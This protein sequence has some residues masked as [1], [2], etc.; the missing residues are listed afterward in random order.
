MPRQT[1]TIGVAVLAS[2]LLVGC[3]DATPGVLGSGGRS[4]TENSGSGGS[5][6]QWGCIG[7]VSPLGAGMTTVRVQLVDTITGYPITSGLTAKRCA[8]IDNTCMSPLTPPPTLDSSA[9]VSVMVASDTDD[10]LDIED[11]NHSYTPTIISLSLVAFSSALQKVQL[12]SNTE[13]AELA[14]AAGI[15]PKSGSSLLVVATDD[16]TN[17]R[18]AGVS[19]AMSPSNGETPFY[20]NGHALNTSGT[21]TDAEGGAGF[22]NVNP[23]PANVVVT[24]TVAATGTVLGTV[25]TVVR[26]GATTWQ[27]LRPTP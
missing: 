9:T 14:S 23:V 25:N 2:T 12:T 3:P 18:A 27:L 16:C 20:L 26:G 21:A 24:G 1:I 11:S 15:T 13:I 8:K 7:H 5:D 4:G 6:A 22:A 19:V 10:Y 17:A